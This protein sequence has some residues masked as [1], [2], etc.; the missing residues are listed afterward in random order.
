[1]SG[2]YG[3]YRFDGAPVSPDVLARMR[4][5]MAYYG[6]DGGASRIDGSLGMGH[7]LLKI[8]PEDT[9][10]TQPVTGRRG[11]VVTSARLDN[12]SELL[13]S[14]DVP[15]ADAP[16]V[17]DGHLVSLAFDRWGDE[18]CAHLQGDWAL[19][20]W[21]RAERKLLL[22]R[23]AFGSSTLYFH[24]GHGFI[25]FASSL[26]ALLALPGVKKEPDPLRLAQVLVSWQHD[27]DRTAYLGF[28]RLVWAQALAIGP[29]GDTRNWRYWSPEG[30]E[31]LRYRR[32]EDYVAA[33][34]EHYS[35]SVQNCLRTSKPVAAKL[36]GGRDSGS[37]VALAAPLL[38]AQGKE[39]TA[40]TSVPL[41]SPDGAPKG[42]LGNE[43]D[44]A[45]ETSVLAG[46]NVRH[47]AVDSQNCGVIQGIDRFLDLHDGPSHAAGNH[48]WLQAISEMA[49]RDG[50]CVVLVG[51][52]GNATVS[53]NG[54]GS[55][56]L[57]LIERQ[58]RLALETLLRTEPNL[59]LT[60]KRQF[61]KPIV[62]PFRRWVRHHGVP[63]GSPW[64]AYSALNP[65]MAEILNIDGRMHA[66]G[67]DPSHTQSPLEDRRA[68]FFK[69]AFS[70]GP[71]IGGDR[72]WICAF[73]LRSDIESRPG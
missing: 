62:T 26:K 15:A 2:F 46:V 40:Y 16:Q 48:Y 37:V 38:A 35:R 5:A 58:P 44:C 28:S 14:F 68:I 11:L 73:Y 21:D 61:V 24:Q 8:N 59:W 67:H 63:Y 31:P 60:L 19:A 17:S 43:W 12:R 9:F 64:R 18:V 29:L 42:R 36:S 50:A 47:I 34:L 33:F 71:S 41:M 3:I 39:L 7:L 51:S 57:Q 54:N 27:A 69:P 65:Q 10:E 53:W 13:D 55:A 20:A 66:A 23:D 70:I 45:H 6:P 49:A 4:D 1:L 32:D 30:R 72:G 52:M 22:A 56:L 25:A